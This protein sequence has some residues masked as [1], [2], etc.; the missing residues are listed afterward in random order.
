L[1]F[2]TLRQH[3]SDIMHHPFHGIIGCDEQA[4]VA[5]RPASQVARGEPTASRATR[6]SFLCRAFSLLAVMTGC[7]SLRT[8]Q[9]STRAL[10]EEG[11]GATTWSW[12]EGGAGGATLRVGE[13]GTTHALGEEGGG[14]TTLRT[15]EEGGTTY[16]LGE[17]GGGVTTL[18][19]GEEG[20]TTRAIGEEGGGATLRVGEEG[21]ATYALGEGGGGLTTLRTGEEGGRTG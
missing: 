3:G 11:G 8:A 21:G 12:A 1:E 14:V 7:G 20:G 15:G 18:R 17:E 10:G 4:E 9:G 2:Q 13:G 6:R 16:A 19:T 5:R